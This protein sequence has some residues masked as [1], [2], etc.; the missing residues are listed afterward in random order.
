MTSSLSTSPPV[1]SPLPRSSSYQPGDPLFAAL[2]T[3]APSPAAGIE[4][5]PFLS[6][7]A[8]SS[9]APS[10]V[11]TPVMK[12]APSPAPSPNTFSF[13]LPAV[14]PV[15][16][17]SSPLLSHP[18]HG[19]AHS[20][21]LTFSSYTDPHLSPS[22]R[23][24][25]RRLEG[26]PEEGSERGEGQPTARPGTSTATK[27]GTAAASRTRRSDRPPQASAASS[28]L[29]SSSSSLS[30]A[31]VKALLDDNKSEA[32]Q[33]LMNLKSLL[34]AGF[35][36]RTEYR[37]RKSQL[38]D[39]M[40]GTTL[41]SITAPSSAAASALT[42]TAATTFSS[43]TTR[44]HAAHH[45]ASS[46]AALD[47][48][49]IVPRGPPDFTKVVAEKATKYT[50]DL[51]SRSW[52]ATSVLVKL[53]PV[54][55]SRGALRLVYH[56]LDLEEAG[57]EKERVRLMREEE[58]R[59]GREER[60]EGEETPS[61]SVSGQDLQALE[62]SG[63]SSIASDSSSCMSTVSSLPSSHDADD[64]CHLPIPSPLSP[65]TSGPSAGATYVAKISMDPRDNEDREIYFRDVEMQ[66]LARYYAH[67]FNEYQPPKLVDF[68]KA[69]ILRLEERE[70]QPLCGVE[71]YIEGTYRKWS[72]AHTHTL[73]LMRTLRVLESATD[74]CV[75]CLPASSALL[76]AVQE[77]QLRVRERGRAQ[78]SAGL[79]SLHV[80]EQQPPAADLRHPGRVRLLH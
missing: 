49:T 21:A 22:H 20:S 58:G 61:V 68:V 42:S 75:V 72:A 59:R 62:H 30:P 4:S 64:G 51:V 43:S 35:I 63:A 55:F 12:P 80:R 17:A 47:L 27:S 65:L 44:R 8:S 31:A 23:E 52:N 48:P 79:Q 19:A 33:K 28:S 50:Y 16:T 71:R 60:R 74:L 53:D 66:T 57:E 54:P 70:G 34:S 46:R 13:A 41:S 7:A 76:C 9:Q 29:V 67:L 37:D 18:S 14:I 10:P 26:V 39:E 36:T 69:S 25:T 56:L 15:L 78:H 73:S 3:S 32:W 5:L 38:I 45:A 1:E 24:G 40:T 2:S 11:A 77:Q 6:S